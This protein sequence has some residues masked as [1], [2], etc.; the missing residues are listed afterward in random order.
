MDA[1]TLT[2][3]GRTVFGLFFL[4]AGIR[5]FVGFG[6]RK[7]N[8]TNYGWLL[9]EPVM[10]AG[11]AAQL[12]GGLAVMAGMWTII[13]ALILIGFL[14]VAT[15]LYHNPLMFQGKERAPHLYLMLVNTTLAAGLLLVIAD[16]M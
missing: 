13:A 16:A 10:A 4:I 11:F 6:E 3:I 1:D 7:T 14:V 9:P 2:L 12:L 8:P 15:A 5:N